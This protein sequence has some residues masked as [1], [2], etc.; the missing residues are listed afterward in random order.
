[1]PSMCQVRV[2]RFEA[3]YLLI[4]RRVR[5]L[6]VLEEVNL[7]FNFRCSHIAWVMGNLQIGRQ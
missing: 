2:P 6:Q 5:Q 7:L 1:M 4:K 3:V